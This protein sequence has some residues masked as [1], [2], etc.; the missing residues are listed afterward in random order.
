MVCE[1]LPGADQQLTS[2]TVG[3]GWDAS[4]RQRRPWPDLP[5]V[6][7][8]TSVPATHRG[9][10][11]GHLRVV[12][13][14]LHDASDSVRKDLLAAEQR[15]LTSPV[16]P[17]DTGVSPGAR[18]PQRDSGQRPRGPRATCARTSTQRAPGAERSM[19]AARGTHARTPGTHAHAQGGTAPTRARPF[20][21]Q[22]GVRPGK[23]RGSGAAAGGR[24]VCGPGRTGKRRAE[25]AGRL[26]GGWGH[27]VKRRPAANLE[28]TRALS[29]THRTRQ[30]PL[31][32]TRG[33]RTWPPPRCAGPGPGGR[34]GTAWPGTGAGHR[35]LASTLTRGGGRGG[36]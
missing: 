33:R 14:T 30:E 20:A 1:K 26:W 23:D 34:L 25:G 22:T 3:S 5:S 27:G 24:R 18:R 7:S 28:V 2:D 11:F 16:L 35:G 17:A 15:P 31:A 19:R 32:S 10:S 6:S 29:T 4:A 13:R 36:D 9:G 12:T 8:C 21:A